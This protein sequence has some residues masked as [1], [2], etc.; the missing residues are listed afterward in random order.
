MLLLCHSA[1]GFS[2]RCMRPITSYVARPLM[3]TQNVNFHRV[4]LRMASDGPIGT[5]TEEAKLTLLI[6][7]KGDEIRQMKA[8]KADKET[9]TPVVE[10]LLQLKKEYE[11]VTGKPFDPPKEGKETTKPA[12][13]AA[14]TK[15]TDTKTPKGANKGKEVKEG[16]SDGPPQGLEDLREVRVGKMK[17]MLAAGV[18]PFAYTYKTTHKTTELVAMAAHLANGQEDESSDVSVAGRIMLRRV[19]GKLAFFTLQDESGQIQLYLEKGISTNYRRLFYIPC[20]HYNTPFY[21]PFTRTNTPFYIH[22]IHYNTP[23]YTPFTRTNTPF[24]TPCTCTSTPFNLTLLHLS[25]HLILILIHLLLILTHSNLPFTHP[26]TPSSTHQGR[27]GDAFETIKEWTDGSD[28]I[29][30]RGTLKRTDKGELSVYVKEW[31]MLTK[32]LLPLPVPGIC[33][34]PRTHP[35]AH[36]HTLTP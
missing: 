16:E 22:C 35:N 6:G 2:I 34:H 13:P 19:F 4:S 21:T 33:T 17:S 28:I 18:N 9:I 30:A 36:T 3:F 32:S 15:P 29:G 27:L 25:T 5:E 7:L 20:I 12:A 23:F 24:Y 8:D 31:T 14:S 11:R 26:N 1:R 10:A